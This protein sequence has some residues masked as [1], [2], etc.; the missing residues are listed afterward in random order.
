MLYSFINI[1]IKGV[2]S[3][4][5]KFQTVGY[6]GTFQENIPVI[7]QRGFTYKFRDDHWLGQG[8]YFYENSK[9]A[10]WFITRK[11]KSQKA[12]SVLKALLSS[13]SNK[14]LDLDSP[15]GINFFYQEIQNILT[16]ANGAITFSKDDP[17]KNRCA[18]LDVI[19]EIHN[20]EIIIHTFERKDRPSYAAVDTNWFD[21]HLFPVD[22]TY[23]EKQICATSNTCIKILLDEKPKNEYIIPTKMYFPSRKKQ[24]IKFKE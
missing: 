7:K 20:I 9:L 12:I 19:K 16:D 22:V 18:M 17:H 21:E 8:F 3:M 23:K 10:H 2:E 6:H 11:R 1:K 15:E 13:E 24:N 14:V 5:E 4:G